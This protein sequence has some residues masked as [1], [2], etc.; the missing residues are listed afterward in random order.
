MRSLL[1][2]SL[3]FALLTSGCGKPGGIQSKAAVQA[4]IEKHL[5]QRPNVTMK[6]LTLEVQEVKFEGDKAEAQVKFQS[7]QSADLTVN[8]RYMLRRVGDHWEV[9][10]ASAT[11][12]MA[13][14]PHAGVGAPK[15]APA[16]PGNGPQPSH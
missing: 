3:G 10:S 9:E 15:P 7:K 8:V 16:P 6:N 11:G 12:G 13:G 5:Q 4:A 1:V 2:C 14:N